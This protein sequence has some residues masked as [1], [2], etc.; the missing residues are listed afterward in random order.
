MNAIS[1]CSCAILCILLL[2]P[3]IYA[4]TIPS[5]APDAPKAEIVGEGILDSRR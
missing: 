1:K 5:S 4:Q 3:S 2:N